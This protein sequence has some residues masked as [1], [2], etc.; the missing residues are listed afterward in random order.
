MLP[1]H[2]PGIST[3]IYFLGRLNKEDG[4]VGYFV[5]YRLG[6]GRFRGAA[7]VSGITGHGEMVL[8]RALGA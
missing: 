3:I 2:Y 7:Y 6:A 8:T 4:G 1:L 5:E